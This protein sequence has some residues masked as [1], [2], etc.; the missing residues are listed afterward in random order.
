MQHKKEF[1]YT[2]LLGTLESCVMAQ[3]VDFMDLQVSSLLQKL[4]D[5]CLNFYLL[6][7]L[8]VGCVAEK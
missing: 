1:Y 5:F 7:L 2:L 6:C 8:K 3:H 4:F